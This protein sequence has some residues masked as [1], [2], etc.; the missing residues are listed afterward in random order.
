MSIPVIYMSTRSYLSTTRL[1]E[2]SVT[3]L[4]LFHPREPSSLSWLCTCNHLLYL[5]KNTTCNLSSLFLLI[6]HCCVLKWSLYCADLIKNQKI[7]HI[8]LPHERPL[9]RQPMSSFRLLPFDF[10]KFLR[11]DTHS[12]CV[13][14]HIWYFWSCRYAI[15]SCNQLSIYCIITGY[16]DF[17]LTLPSLLCCLFVASNM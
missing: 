1:R 17:K 16:L 11:M 14:E 13:P 12:E 8:S 2:V 4:L 15:V 3:C 6:P 10:N 5:P 7:L 9:F